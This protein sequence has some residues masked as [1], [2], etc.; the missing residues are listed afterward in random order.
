MLPEMSVA[1]ASAQFEKELRAHI[2]AQQGADGVCRLIGTCEKLH[3][4]C[5]VMR[6]YECNLATVIANAQP[7]LSTALSFHPLLPVTERNRVFNP[8]L[9]PAGTIL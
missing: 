2:T 5:L 8:T 3:R 6:R 4:L 7:G 9:L 1:E